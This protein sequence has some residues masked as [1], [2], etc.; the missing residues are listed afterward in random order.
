MRENGKR[1]GLISWHQSNRQ[2]AKR[3]FVIEK[4]IKL[5]SPKKQNKIT[6]DTKQQTKVYDKAVV[7]LECSTN[8]LGTI[9]NCV[10]SLEIL[11]DGSKSLSKAIVFEH[12]KQT[13]ALRW[14]L[15]YHKKEA[16]EICWTFKYL[17]TSYGHKLVKIYILYKII[18]YFIILF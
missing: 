15:F 17:K 1:S 10:K 4:S 13:S 12:W 7:T 8:K 2:T 18:F 6:L 14:K 5:T 16:H 11:Q 3:K 9:D